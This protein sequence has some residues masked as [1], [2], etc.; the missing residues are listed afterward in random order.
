MNTKWSKDVYF[1]VRILL[2]HCLQLLTQQEKQFV[3]TVELL[4]KFQIADD[5]HL[6]KR[7]I[8]KNYSM[9]YS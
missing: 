3:K 8:L 6:S 1:Q 5:V 4:L 2:N 9:H 7:I